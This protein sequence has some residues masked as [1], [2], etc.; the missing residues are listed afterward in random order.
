MIQNI[1]S[2]QVGYVADYCMTNN[3]LKFKK[4]YF[5]YFMYYNSGDFGK[6]CKPHPDLSCQDRLLA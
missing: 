1:I 6:F 5:K 2:S 3:E 4:S